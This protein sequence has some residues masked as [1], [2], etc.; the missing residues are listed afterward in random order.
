MILYK[1]KITNLWSKN[2]WEWEHEKNGAI[3][4]FHTGYDQWSERFYVA[5]TE[6]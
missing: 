2:L 4:W 5:K 3:S 1:G 6:D